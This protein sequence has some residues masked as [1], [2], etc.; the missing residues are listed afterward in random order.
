MKT[1][2]S[3]TEAQKKIDD[4]F[5]RKSFS[6]EEVRKIKRLAMKFNIK[7]GIY[8]RKFCKKCLSQLKGKTR[9]TKTHKIIECAS[10]GAKNRQRITFK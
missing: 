3:R 7:L 6:S 8:R 10:C 1:Q 9:T 4:F 2:L 5:E